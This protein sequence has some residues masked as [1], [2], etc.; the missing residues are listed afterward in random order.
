KRQL[1]NRGLGKKLSSHHAGELLDLVEDVINDAA[2][3]QM[4]VDGQLNL[5]NTASMSDVAS[6]RSLY[7]LID[8]NDLISSLMDQPSGTS[9]GHYPVQVSLGSELSNDLLKDYSLLTAEYSVG[10]HGK[11]VIALLGPNNMPYSQ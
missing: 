11:G 10:S 5:L 1:L 8:H 7:E 2:S 3:E 6:L 9:I 4:Y